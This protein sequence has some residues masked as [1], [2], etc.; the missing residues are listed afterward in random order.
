MEVFVDLEPGA[1]IT[2]TITLGP[3]ANQASVDCQ[4][5][6]V[7]QQKLQVVPPPLLFHHV[8]SRQP[9]QLPQALQGQLD[10]GLHLKQW[11]KRTMIL[12]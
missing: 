8:L 6:V 2:I 3:G 4:I 12:L 10:V 7:G 11:E 1:S 5:V 9:L